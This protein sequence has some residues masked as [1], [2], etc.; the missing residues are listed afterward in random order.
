M[1]PRRLS[2]LFRAGAQARPEPQ[3]EPAPAAE[4]LRIGEQP[5]P[6]ALFTSSFRSTEV[7]ALAL[8]GLGR[9]EEAADELRRVRGARTAMNGFNRRSYSMLGELFP[10]GALD[11]VLEVWREILA[12]DPEAAVPE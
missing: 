10:P 11:A 4:S 2:R 1:I 7:R 8:A 9:G 3:A 6:Y 12:E 5:L